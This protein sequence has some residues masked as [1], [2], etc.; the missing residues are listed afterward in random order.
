M[1]VIIL[2]NFT[3]FKK[4]PE[5]F[6]SEWLDIYLYFDLELRTMT[7]ELIIHDFGW[8]SWLRLLLGT[9]MILA[10]VPVPRHSLQYAWLCVTISIAMVGTHQSYIYWVWPYL[11]LWYRMGI[12]YSYIIAPPWYNCDDWVMANK[13]FDIA[14]SYNA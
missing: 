8:L 4:K 12:D 2:L 9:L 5:C 3:A 7:M 6:Y 10:C 13:T 11:Y 14:W 1:K